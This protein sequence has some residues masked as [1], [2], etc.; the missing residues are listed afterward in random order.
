MKV[1]SIDLQRFDRVYSTPELMRR[2]FPRI[3]FCYL[4]DSALKDGEKG[5]GASSFIM[6]KIAGLERT[7]VF[8]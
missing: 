5:R 4:K 1:R 2:P 7:Y 8:A 3:S 6:K